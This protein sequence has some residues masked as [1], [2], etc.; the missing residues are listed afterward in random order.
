MG[1]ARLPAYERYRDLPSLIR[2]WPH[3]IRNGLHAGRLRVLSHVTRAMRVER[4]RAL[5]GRRDYDLKRHLALLCALKTEQADFAELEAWPS[6]REALT[7]R[8][9]LR[10]K[11][12]LPPALANKCTTP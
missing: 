10:A 12:G 6:E 8:N 2:L 11:R 9:A 7:G 1:V 4:R 5:V 3:E